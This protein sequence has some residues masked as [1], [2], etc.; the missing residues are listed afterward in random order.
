LP[1]IERTLSRAREAAAGAS[2]WLTATPALPLLAALCAVQLGIGLWIALATTHNHFVWYS[3]GDATEYWTG[4]WSLAHGQIGQTIIGYGVPVL[5]A[6]VP[7]VT[8][9]TLFGG[10]PVIAS[11]QWLVFVP[12]AL[13]LF[14]AVADL[15][16]G[17]L[18]AWWASVLWLAGPPLLLAGFSASYRGEFENLFL[19]PHWFGLTDMADLPSLVAALATAWAALRLL[20]R[21]TTDDA[22]LA[23]L[24][25]GAL[26][27]LKPANGF[28]LPALALVLVAVR[29]LAPLAAFGAA[30]VPALV[31][32][33][34]WKERGLGSLPVASSAAARE[35][36]T[37][38]PLLAAPNKYLQFNWS[39]LQQELHDLG[40]VFWS[41]RL[42]EFLAVAGALA[43]LRRSRLKGAFVVLWFAGF[44]LVKG[45]SGRSA[46]VTVSYWRFVEPG[47]PA[48]ILL[49]AATVYLVP[50]SG[51]AFAPASSPVPLAG[52]RPTLGAAAV[53]LAV[54]PLLLLIAARPAS[55]AHYARIEDLA[56]DAPLTSKMKPAA[57]AADGSV[58]LTWSPVSTGAT[59]AY[60]GVYRSS[61]G[62][63][64]TPPAAGAQACIVEMDS[65]GVTR[66]PSFVD[67]PG[68]GIHWYRIALLAN[69]RDALD[70]SDLM[71]LGPA[72][73]VRTAR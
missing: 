44:C 13:V 23:G 26:I 34:L 40:D 17:R 43:A 46:I 29:K 32:L 11:L 6:W 14:W 39:H 68:A 38:Q 64:C 53:L 41:V 72:T 42:L 24:L 50:R 51:R 15:L 20:E 59:R 3:G 28:F 5:W 69:F 60:Y 19:A 47:L 62:N 7:L 2:G 73:R 9:T 65:V 49:V 33:A 36:A 16:F 71:L 58:H 8:G 67:R 56:N 1:G 12:L 45:S 70:G 61:N 52:G 31:T 4:S 27:G 10:L 48:F 37:A 21:R 57:A 30:F 66:A 22:V 54:V 63:G 55:S 35:A 25:A 18:F